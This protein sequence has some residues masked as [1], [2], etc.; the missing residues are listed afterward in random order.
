MLITS[1]KVYKNLEIKK[2]YKEDDIIGG[3]DPYSA[4]K[5]ATE[6]L[7]NSY[8]KSFFKKGK[9][10]SIAIA[11]AGNVIGGGDW[12]EDRLVPDCIRASSKKK[13]SNNQK[14]KSTRPWQ[15]VLESIRLYDVGNSTEKNKN[16][17]GEAFNFGPSSKFEKNV[18][19]LVKEMK[20]NW[21]LIN[22]EI[23][24]NTKYNES[25]LL[26]LNSKKAK[27]ILKWECLLSFKE[28]VKIVTLWYK[29]YYIKKNDIFS[30]SKQQ[31]NNYQNKILKK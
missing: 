13:K 14:S 20:K 16:L 9:N 3:E 17:H 2:G 4:S 8:I 15:H 5:G 10:I 23:K 28:T 21:Q 11:R 7:I 6:I 19:T 27:K 25:K 18:I 24:K 12:S 31:I 30:F 22:W 1:D 26:K 29:N